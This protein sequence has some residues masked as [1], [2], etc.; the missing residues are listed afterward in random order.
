MYC[1]KDSDLL[2]EKIYVFHAAF[3]FLCPSNV[4]RFHLSGGIFATATASLHLCKN[5]SVPQFGNPQPLHSLH[6]VSLSPVV[7]SRCSIPLACGLKKQGQILFSVYPCVSNMEGCRRQV[8]RTERFE[9]ARNTATRSVAKGNA[10]YP[11][12][13]LLAS[14]GKSILPVSLD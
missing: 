2:S 5:R 4:D 6:Y 1:P 3:V 7:A 8:R 12:M 9:R 11:A 14:A 13:L 10:L